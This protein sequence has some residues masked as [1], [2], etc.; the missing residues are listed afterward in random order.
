L[1]SPNVAFFLGHVDDANP[2]A[3]EQQAARAVVPVDPSIS[4]ASGTGDFAVRDPA[5]GSQRTTTSNA[6][7]LYQFLDV[8]PGDYRLEAPP[9]T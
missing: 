9:A 6:A 8:P 2:S 7:G 3:S 1:S 4:A 5:N